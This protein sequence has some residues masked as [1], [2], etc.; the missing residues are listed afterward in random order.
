MDYLHSLINEGEQKSHFTDC[1]SLRS[2]TSRTS[3]SIARK[4]AKAE[5]AKAKALY[6]QREAALRKQRSQFEEEQSIAQASMERRKADLEADLQ[7]LS[8]EK[9]AAAA[10]AEAD[11]F[12][13]IINS[14]S[15]TSPTIRQLPLPTIC[16]NSKQRRCLL[17]QFV[18]PSM[19]PHVPH[20]MQGS[21]FEPATVFSPAQ[22]PAMPSMF[23]S[24]SFPPP[25][26]NTVIDFTQ[27]LLKKDLLLS[28][29][30]KY[31]D[32]PENY[33]MWSSS[34]RN[35][36]LELNVKPAEE[37]DLLVKWSSRD[38]R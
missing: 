4:Q 25:S 11:S 5:A 30:Y 32:L 33:L 19:Y 17:P 28:R 1:G 2:S 24:P 31:D 12:E 16:R 7:L 6:A 34:F 3:S 26:K 27:F 21:R 8:E 14:D 38:V 36:A 23:D 18:P 13:D 15:P 20:P 22:Q 37:L 29:L 35:I 9:E 10:V